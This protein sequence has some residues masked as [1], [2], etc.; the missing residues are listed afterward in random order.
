M[1]READTY[2]R[3][4]ALS[5]RQKSVVGF[6]RTHPGCITRDIAAYMGERPQDLNATLQSL[7]KRQLIG[8]QTSLVFGEFDTSWYPEVGA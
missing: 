1:T 8:K 4:S 5:A 7:M 2:K 3:G 6:I